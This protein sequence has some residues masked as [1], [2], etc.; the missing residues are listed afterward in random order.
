MQHWF[1]W[2]LGPEL[3]WICTYAVARWL[4]HGNSPPTE[5]G[6]QR[7]ER[8]TILVPCAAVALSFVWCALLRTSR[9]GAL[10][11]LLLSGAVGVCI[12]TLTMVGG[13]HY[14]DSRNAGLLALWFLA[15][16]ASAGLLLIGTLVTGLA[17]VLAQRRGN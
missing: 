16:M 4:V 17:L 13:V 15:L 3:L 11:R 8:W 5:L 10:A 12:V 2:L 14:R 7:L 9:W 6:S 1:G